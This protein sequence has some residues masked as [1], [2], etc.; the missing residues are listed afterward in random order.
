MSNWGF[1]IYNELKELGV[2]LNIPCF[3][4]R[5]DQLTAAEVKESQSGASIRIHD[6]ELATQRV[7]KFRVLRNEIPLSLYGSMNQIWI[8]SRY[9]MQFYETV[10]SE[11]HGKW[12]IHSQ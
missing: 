5:R 10:N 1:I 11:R 9:V 4:A 2:V 6:V 8:V 12:L 7:K 3:L